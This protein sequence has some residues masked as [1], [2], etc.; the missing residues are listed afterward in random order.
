MCKHVYICMYVYVL[1]MYMGVYS[2]VY[3]FL[4]VDTHVFM[5][6]LVVL[7]TGVVLAG[8]PNP[9]RICAHYGLDT[10]AIRRLIHWMIWRSLL[11]CTVKT[12]KRFRSKT[13]S[14]SIYSRIISLFIII[15]SIY[16][17]LVSFYVTI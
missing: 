2:C 5:G 11:V 17:L 7:G 4:C 8:D 6:V 15:S 1:H 3:L 13:V 14:F 10:L 16:M 9:I 12:R